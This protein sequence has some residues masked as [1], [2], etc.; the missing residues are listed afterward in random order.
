MFARDLVLK[1]GGHAGVVPGQQL[2][3]WIS[4]SLWK[5]PLESDFIICFKKSLCF[6][7]VS[8]TIKS[9]LLLA[10]AR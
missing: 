3:T 1:E 5:I 7:V 8:F 6:L 9:K 2:N 10:T 4:L